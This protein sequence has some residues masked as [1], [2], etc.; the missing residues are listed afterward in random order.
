MDSQKNSMT[1][2]SGGSHSA[3]GSLCSLG[4]LPRAGDAWGLL[5]ELKENIFCRS[6]GRCHCH[7]WASISPGQ[8][9][10]GSRRGRG[11][12]GP[13]GGPDCLALGLLVLC[14]R[15]ATFCDGK[16]D[17]HQLTGNG[18]T[19]FSVRQDRCPQPSCLSQAES[20]CGQ[21]AQFPQNI[22]RSCSQHHTRHGQPAGARRG[23]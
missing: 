10:S 9:E 7:C 22:P 15:C 19:A 2:L 11:S 17:K 23:P 16:N 18:V 1:G 5:F 20:L 3:A 8:N 12:P 6:S 13:M 21:E 14:R 4:C